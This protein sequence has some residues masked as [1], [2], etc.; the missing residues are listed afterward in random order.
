MI[1][2]FRVKNSQPTNL[3]GSLW[4]TNF[5]EGMQL[6]LEE[7]LSMF[8]DKK[9]LVEVISHENR[10]EEDKQKEIEEQH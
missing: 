3:W 1:S 4:K 2:K 7:E 10:I 8:E 9:R 5:D 6:R